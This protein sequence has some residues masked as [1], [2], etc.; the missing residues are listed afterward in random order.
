MSPAPGPAASAPLQP[1][2]PRSL[3]QLMGDAR[4][5]PYFFGGLLSSAGV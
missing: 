5:G 2:Q 3:F 1:P 4:M